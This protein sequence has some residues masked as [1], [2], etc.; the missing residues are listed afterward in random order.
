MPRMPFRYILM[1]LF[2]W[3]K[4]SLLTVR[5][6]GGWFY[7]LLVLATCLF[8]KPAFKHVV[9][10]GLVL[11][12]DGRKMSKR[13]KNYPDPKDI[14]DQYGADALRLPHHHARTA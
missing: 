5:L 13:L 3:P 12:E 7:S 4:L 14:I 11:A 10:N 1:G 2:L 6:Q 9:V 8:D